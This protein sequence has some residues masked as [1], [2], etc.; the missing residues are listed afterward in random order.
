MNMVVWTLGMQ[1]YMSHPEIAVRNAWST[2]RLYK[3]LEKI[4]NL[5]LEPIPKLN[6]SPA[7]MHGSGNIPAWSPRMNTMMFAGI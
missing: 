7:M 4:R 3:E 1:S 5:G 2:E 6:F